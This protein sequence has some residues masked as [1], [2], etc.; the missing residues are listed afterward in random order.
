MAWLTK[1]RFMAGMQCPRR[2]WFEVHEPLAAGLPASLALLNGREVDRVAQT[3]KP[4]AVVTRERGMPAAIAETARLLGSGA[5]PVMYQ[6]AFRAG[7][8]AVIA[9]VLEIRAGTA[10]LTEVKSSTGLKPEHLP[11][12]T[13]QT[14]V[15]RNAGQPVDRV[16]LA[17]VDRGFRLSKEGDYAGLLAH[18][19]IT[20]EVEAALPEVAEASA[21]L[22]AVMTERSRPV[23]RMGAQCTTPY[24]CPFMDRCA[25]QG[26]DAPAYPV[27]LLPRG[28]KTVAA[29]LAEG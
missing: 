13:F 17:Y 23:V 28:G 19:D 15:I 21:R 4:G 9:D 7:D 27:A 2:L 20:G 24:E 22:R 6:P 29:L 8:L 25:A 12:A 10:T 5:A 11:D 14:L 3:L 18:A 26:G 16:L 1:S